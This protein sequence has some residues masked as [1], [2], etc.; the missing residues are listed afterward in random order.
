MDYACESRIK[1]KWHSGQ[2]ETVPT[3]LGK[4]TPLMHTTH[5]PPRDLIGSA[6]N[7]NAELV[8]HELVTQGFGM[9][10]QA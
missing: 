1:S 6:M 5:L 8:V 10:S 4:S 2:Y 3:T 9:A 7:C